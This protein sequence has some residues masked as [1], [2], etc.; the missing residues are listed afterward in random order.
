MNSSILSF[1]QPV[2][3]GKV[4]EIYAAGDSCIIVASDRISAFDCILP[5]LIPEKGRV[6]STLSSWWFDRTQHI[7][8][9]HLI[10]SA[11][12]EFP[13]PFRGHDAW[14]GRAMLVRRAEV[15]PV[16]CVVR[17]YLAGSGWKEYQNSQ[18]VCGEKLPAGLQESSRLP[19]PI[20]TPTTKAEV[21]DHDEPIDFARAEE[22]LGVEM[23]ARVREISLQ[24][25]RFAADLADERGLI[26]ADTKFEFGLVNGELTLVDEIFTPDSSRFWDA[27]DYAPG[28]AQESFD[29]Q[30]VR[31]YLEALNWNKMP[32]APALPSTIVLQ[33]Q[34]KYFAAYER[35]TG[36]A[37]PS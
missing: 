18:S 31:D 33:T 15:L 24:L 2:R 1:P 36:Q 7:V 20:F 27:K 11:V 10:S 28:R 14:R 25:Y 9:N 4:R 12:D 17:G 16:E 13:S 30:F 29:K 37:W 5:T 19:Q 26:L 8:D 21:G 22:I 6:L 32:P 35:I 23:A 34:S 3:T